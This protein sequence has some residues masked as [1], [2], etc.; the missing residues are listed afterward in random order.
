LDGAASIGLEI[1]GFTGDFVGFGEGDKGFEDLGLI[2][3]RDGFGSAAA[4]LGTT[5]LGTTGLGANGF[6][7]SVWEDSE[8]LGLTTGFACSTT[9]SSAGVS[10]LLA[11]EEASAVLV[12]SSS[13]IGSAGAWLG[14]TPDW[15]TI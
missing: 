3:G 13:S 11:V 12:V 5:G 1:F 2:R 10:V 7:G 6:I 9:G 14:A 8:S 15:D 4:G